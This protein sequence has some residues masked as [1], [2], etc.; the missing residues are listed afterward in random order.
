MV[1]F[2]PPFGRNPSVAS[3]GTYERLELI[4]HPFRIPVWQPDR[5][6][7]TSKTE[8]Q[9]KGNENDSL[10]IFREHQKDGEDY[11]TDMYMARGTL[12]WQR[13]LRNKSN[14]TT[15]TEKLRYYSSSVST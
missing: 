7:P 15:M 9:F 3:I 2:P 10:N 4:S 11:A 8:V 12:V 5:S 1:H 13:L 6:E 14:S